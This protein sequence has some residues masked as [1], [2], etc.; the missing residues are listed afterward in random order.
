[1]RT[2]LGFIVHHNRGFLLG[3]AIVALL[4][5]GGCQARTH[6][7]P[8]YSQS[9]RYLFNTQIQ[10]TRTL[11]TPISSN[12]AKAILNKRATRQSGSRA[13]QSKGRAFSRRASNDIAAT[14]G[15]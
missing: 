8:Y 5:L 2:P 14:L 15:L 10:N 12:D 4:M 9:Y 7:S 1:M 6:L 3:L 11:V 13:A